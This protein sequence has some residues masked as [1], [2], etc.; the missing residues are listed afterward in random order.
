MAIDMAIHLFLPDENA[1][2]FNTGNNSMSIIE[3]SAN[4]NYQIISAPLDKPRLSHLEPW[5][6]V[7]DTWIMNIDQSY[8]LLHW[9][10]KILH[11]YLLLLL[12]I[13]EDSESDPSKDL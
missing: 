13:N 7:P 12:L 9:L 6:L 8:I 2:K 1:Y 11:R 5:I 4:Q 10:Y 3:V